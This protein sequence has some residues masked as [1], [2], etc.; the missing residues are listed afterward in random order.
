MAYNIDG[1]DYLTIPEAVEYMGCTDGWVRML[2]REGK[3]ES[4][5][6][7]KRLRLVA[8]RSATHVRDTLSTRAVG[9]KHLAKRPAAKRKKAKRKR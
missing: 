5:L 4:R 6:L 7:G 2:C 8:K 9:K 1:V 3:L